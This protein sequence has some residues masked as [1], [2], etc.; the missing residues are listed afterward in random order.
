MYL[1]LGL[2]RSL[3]QSPDAPAT[4][5]GDRVRSFREQADR[6]ARLAGALRE[7]GVRD[8]ERVGVLALNSDRY[9]EFLL[10][11]PWANGVLNPVNIRWSPAEIV[12][13]LQDSQTGILFVDDA[14]ASAVPAL[15]DGYSG[16]RTV[17]YL[18]DGSPPAGML[19]YEEL[20]SGAQPV[21]DARRGGDALAG[22]FYTGGT[23]GFPK[24]VMLSHAN[25]LISALGD[26][27][28]VP[29]RVPGERVLHAAPM[30]HLV[31]L[32]VG[33]LGGLLLGG[34]H[35]ILPAFDPAAVIETIER[36]QVRSV[37][38]VPTMLQMVA[39]HPAVADHDLSSVR[40]VG[41]G[42]SPI[43]EAVLARA[44]KAF[45]A[46]SLRQGYGMTELAPS[47]TMLGPDEHRV[48][49]NLRSAGRP[50]VNV[51]VQIV[52]A[53]DNEVPR[54]TVGE[55]VCRGGNVMLGYWNKPEETAQA[56]RG[57]WMHTGDAGYMDH[58][59]YVYVVDRMKDMIVSG[60]ENVYSAEVENA[61]GSHPAVA[62]CAVIGVP[63]PEWG[64]R[65]HAIIVLKPD[66]TASA[67]DIRDHCKTLIAGY[68]APRSCE[69][70]D[71]LPM[72][73]TGK[74]LKRELRKP[75]W[76]GKDRYVH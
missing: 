1:T 23:T 43:T 9:A 39:D 17:V 62:A 30:F 71:A 64:E 56:V 46:A 37:L 28:T 33:W 36:H 50:F 55:I 47:A 15:G 74:P 19:S 32:G 16:L 12:Y 42:G 14:F 70:V 48:G 35:V 45:P 22:L 5:F 49:K 65:V 24:G 6:V 25:L 60:G 59:G 3:Q 20:I 58:D 57:G 54:R 13:S 52:D 4:I 40:N 2:H 76:E 66:H 8:G 11:V 26:Q 68:K 29:A 18:G 69:F 75:Y 38:L 10:A 72:S 73:P 51:E 44:M 31:A 67:D 53:D 41:Y 27:A 61:V 7:L 34:T 63:D 21:E